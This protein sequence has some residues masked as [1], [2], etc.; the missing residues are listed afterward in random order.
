MDQ[1]TCDEDR[2]PTV[3]DADD[4]LAGSGGATKYDTIITLPV[5]LLR[6]DGGTQ[7]RAR[8]D[9]SIVEDYA[10]AM[11][12]G[13]QFPPLTVFYDGSD[14][15][16]A[17][18]FHRQAAAE[19][20]ER[21]EIAVKVCQGTRRDAILYSC[22]ANANHGL[23]RSNADKER[24]VQMLLRDEEWRQWND[25]ELARR[26][27]VD[28]K[29]VTRIRHA[30]EV[31][32]EIPTSASRLVTRAGATFPLDTSGISAANSER[33]DLSAEHRARGWRLV[34]TEQDEHAVYWAERPGAR[35]P[36]PGFADSITTLE[37]ELDGLT[38]EERDFDPAEEPVQRP[39]PLTRS[40]DHPALPSELVARGWSLFEDPATGTWWM[41][42][43]P[44]ARMS[45]SAWDG[46]ATPQVT[47]AEEAIEDARAVESLE[48]H[49]WSLCG[50]PGA[51]WASEGGGYLRTMYSSH[52]PRTTEFASWTAV[53]A[54]VRAQER[55]RKVP[56][57]PPLRETTVLAS[58][59]LWGG[60]QPGAYE[61]PP[62]SR[63]AVRYHTVRDGTLTTVRCIQEDG[64]DIS[65]PPDQVWRLVDEEAWT[66]AQ[67]LY[68]DFQGAL[69]AL[70]DQLADLGTYAEKLRAAGGQKK[71]PECL[72][73]TVIA[74][75]EPG[76]AR[77]IWFNRWHVPAVVRRTI[78]RHTPQMLEY[79]SSSGYYVSRV[80]Q[81]DHFVC[82]SDDAWRQ[83]ESCYR[84]AIAAQVAW[85]AFLRENSTYAQAFARAA[86]GSGAVTNTHEPAGDEQLL[87]R[88]GAASRLSALT[89]EGEPPDRSQGD[90]TMDDA[91]DGAGVW[92]TDGHIPQW[93]APLSE[94]EHVVE[95][96]L[97]ELLGHA[98]DR[99][100]RSVLVLLGGADALDD[101]EDEPET[102]SASVAALLLAHGWVNAES[103]DRVKG[104]LV[105]VLGLRTGPVSLD[106]LD[107]AG[108]SP[109]GL[110]VVP[111]YNAP[112]QG[113][114]R[115]RELRPNDRA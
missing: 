77:T 10:I 5:T 87:V 89:R 82:P 48:R 16:V 105:T 18:G 60:D 84:R 99:L 42:T 101:I 71:A 92:A 59:V 37:R 21:S 14:Y 31:S 102:V 73:P 112:G 63:Y 68:R 44:Y 35:W 80:N 36:A 110:A 93:E 28:H 90:S 40:V 25:S 55:E 85:D 23:R 29:T 11:R 54:A 98:N 46:R 13:A 19:K 83:V 45:R 58:H 3:V 49:G 47:S 22:G 95:Q 67:H 27:F 76:R 108:A 15:W 103:D 51:W 115:M 109:T 86:E 65:R 107:G 113:L 52:V 50:E 17:D 91:V 114:A 4:A 20:V 106:A 81:T 1:N 104:A 41:Q 74:A 100:V 9:P 96:R 8:L 94:L 6:T 62:L 97:A 24:A 32:G 53:A 38:R 39:W 30:M 26:S 66:R 56:R 75:E 69:T 33:A 79:E 64:T 43:S 72:C 88:S 34:R 78:T 70:A 61:L 111:D 57:T 12:E 2:R 7:T